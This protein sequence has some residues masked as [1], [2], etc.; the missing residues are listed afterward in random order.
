MVKYQLH[1]LEFSTQLK[2]KIFIKF[3]SNFIPIKESLIIKGTIRGEKLLRV[4]IMIIFCRRLMYIYNIHTVYLTFVILWAV[5][6]GWETT[7]TEQR[8]GKLVHKIRM[9]RYITC[10][11][12]SRYIWAWIYTFCTHSSIVYMYI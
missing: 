8:V 3:T 9:Y 7:T 12:Y 11:K 6:S 2:H 5:T 4:I 10:T 1:T